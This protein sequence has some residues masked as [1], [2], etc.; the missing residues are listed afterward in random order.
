MKI[1]IG[2]MRVL[3]NQPQKNYET[4]K[5]IIELLDA[6]VDAI[7]FPELCISGAH[8]GDKLLNIDYQNDILSYNEKIAR[9]SESVDIIWGNLVREEILFNGGYYAS[10]GVIHKV[11]TKK[12]LSNCSLENESRYFAEGLGYEIIEIKGQKFN[13]A[14]GNDRLLVD[15][16]QLILNPSS[17]VWSSSKDIMFENCLVVNP[18]GIQNNGK[19]VVVL[20]GASYLKTQ[21][22]YY[23][24]TE[25]FIEN[26]TII[27]LAT[28]YE[29]KTMEPS[30][31]DALLAA[32]KMFDEECLAYGP[33][34]LVGVS[35]GLD[36]SLSVALLS[37]ALGSE[38]V[39]GVTMPGTYT[40]DITKSNAYHLS[41]NFGFDLR[42]IPIKDMVEST[43]SSLNKVGYDTVE[44]LSYENIQARLRGHTLM[45]VAS[46]ENGVVVNNGN[47]IETA[48]GY[49][50]L[51][52]DAIG[53]LSLLGDL[54]KIEVGEI[55]QEINRR[56]ER[57][58]IPNNL[59]PKVTDKNIEWEFAPSAEL[60][61][62]QFD[63]MK[64]GYHD[65]LIPYI[66]HHS[67]EAVM[68]MYLDG[69]IYDEPI[70]TYLK[71]Y[72]LDDSI[73]FIDDLEWVINTMH[74]ATYKR[75]Q[76]PPLIKLSKL[77]FGSDYQESQL[78]NTKTT[79]YKILKERILNL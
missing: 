18:V 17:M 59:I 79:E 30:V 6:S 61:E 26:I 35:G 77:S 60:S 8:V 71:F 27:D 5:N 57:E 76:L 19:N 3:A 51:Y 11:V 53:A 47:K 1:A 33:K 67:V 65:L 12:N 41:Q 78:P 15:A 66:M 29:S 13:L 16:E 42:E 25:N 72:H 75:I 58:M 43:V 44:G 64:W 45:S 22:S 21:N 55:A 28:S 49:A 63:P 69:S 7:I 36:S 50:T 56:Y 68:R 24:N 54:T 14:I 74:T 37:M 9:L 40:R 39:L 38:R 70:G 20:N 31:L 23:Q 34:W 4:I 73:A 52:G 2:Q 48:L 62:D 46:L 32:I 10:K